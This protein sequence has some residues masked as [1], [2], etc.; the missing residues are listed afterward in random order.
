MAFVCSLAMFA[1][2]AWIVPASNQ[3]F[4]VTFAAT[5]C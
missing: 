5:T 2:F 4:R 1:M 3:A